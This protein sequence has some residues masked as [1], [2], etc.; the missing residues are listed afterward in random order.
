MIN[1][2][3]LTEQTDPFTHGKVGGLSY[4]IRVLCRQIYSSRKDKP[5]R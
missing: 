4:E 1:N 3:L 5:N 2:G